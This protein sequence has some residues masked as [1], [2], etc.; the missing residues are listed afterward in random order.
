MGLAVPGPAC[1]NTL[2]LGLAGSSGGRSQRGAPGAPTNHTV[3]VQESGP[4]GWCGCFR[5]VGKPRQGWR[6]LQPAGMGDRGC[7]TPAPQAEPGRRKLVGAAYWHPPGCRC[8]SRP[9]WRMWGEPGWRGTGGSS[10]CPRPACPA[11]GSSRSPGGAVPQH[12]GARGAAAPARHRST[13]GGGQGLLCTAPPAGTV[14][15]PWTGPVGALGSHHGTTGE[16]GHG[17]GH[18]TSGTRD[19]LRAQG[20]GLLRCWARERCRVQRSWQWLGAGADGHRRCY[21]PLGSPSCAKTPSPGLAQR[22]RLRAQVTPAPCGCCCSPL[23]SLPA[24]VSPLPAAESQFARSQT[25]AG[26]AGVPGRRGSGPALPAPLPLHRAP[27]G[28]RL[29]RGAGSGSVSQRPARGGWGGSVSGSA[30]PGVALG[31]G[32]APLS[33]PLRQVWGPRRVLGGQRGVGAHSAPRPPQS[34]CWMTSCSP[35]RSSCPP[36]ASCSSCTSNILGG[37][38]GGSRGAWGGHWGAVRVGTRVP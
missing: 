36:S 34:R 35:T 16:H 18:H 4:R 7:L 14:L 10:L 9:R 22:T 15:E 28:P 26:V 29:P 3:L 30:S 21:R 8:P 20:R 24:S 37:T 13:A 25:F 31:I 19:P 12:G 32:I 5:A 11:F 27:A 17:H 23:P 2:L 1:T 38:G 6:V 33:S